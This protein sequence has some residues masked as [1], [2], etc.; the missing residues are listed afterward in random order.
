MRRLLI[1]ALVGA[2]LLAPLGASAADSPYRRVGKSHWSYQA[3]RFLEGL[4]YFAGT[5]AD[6]FSGKKVLTRYAFASAFERMYPMLQP[7]VLAATA[8]GTLK[9][10]VAALSRLLNE[11][12]EEIS[13]LG[14]DLQDLR[15]ELRELEERVARL[16]PERPVTPASALDLAL[17]QRAQRS[18]GVSPALARGWAAGGPSPTFGAVHTPPLSLQPAYAANLGSLRVALGVQRPDS[19]SF[20]EDVPFQD[21]TEGASFSG[22]LSYLLEGYAIRAFYGS[23]GELWDRYGFFSPYVNVGAQSGIGGAVSGS[24]TSRLAFEL[25]AASLKP[26]DAD[27]LR[28]TTYLRGAFQFSLGK[29]Y[30]LDLG[31]EFAKLGLTDAELAYQVYS[32]G[33]GRRFGNAQLSVLYRYYAPGNGGHST[34]ADGGASGAVTQISV[35]F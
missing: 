2:F 35:R 17:T 9:D 13:S 5:P 18:Y 28:K 8:P 34:A 19:L 26:E 22:E 14:T 30:S 6:T 27:E 11:Y 23:Q 15:R 1:T 31:V 20:S 4:G 21:P 29:G 7:R 3:V 12:G 24:L 10:E 25:L 16:A 33:F 32:M